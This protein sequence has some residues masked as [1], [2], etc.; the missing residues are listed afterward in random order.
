KWHERY[1]LSLLFDEE[2]NLVKGS[3]TDDVGCFTIVG[4]YSTRTLRMGLKKIY[5]AGTGNPRENLG[6]T[7]TIQ[8]KWNSNTNQFEGKW[9]ILNINIKIVLK[10]IVCRPG[11]AALIIRCTQ[12]PNNIINRLKSVEQL[13]NSIRFLSDQQLEYVLCEKIFKHNKRKQSL[14]SNVK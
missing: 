13:C 5:R 2:Q 7:V 10:I 1:E 3:G 9:I 4:I 11:I 12:E 14:N 6:Y 8:L